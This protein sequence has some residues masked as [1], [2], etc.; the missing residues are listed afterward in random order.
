MFQTVFDGLNAGGEEFE[1]TLHKG[2]AAAEMVADDA[3][4]AVGFGGRLQQTMTAPAWEKPEALRAELPSANG[5][6]NAR[7]I[8]RIGSIFANGGSLGGHQFLSGETI[9][10]VLTEQIYKT[11]LLIGDPVR[12]GFGLG[13]RSEEFPCPSDESMHWGGAGGSMCIMDRKSG[14]CVAYVMNG[15][16]AGRRNDP[17]GRAIHEAYLDCVAAL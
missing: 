3:D 2:V 5:V 17:R 1:A 9:D 14:T 6:G 10:L 11:C 13:I 8:S 16:L 4:V 15:M 12:F 7:S